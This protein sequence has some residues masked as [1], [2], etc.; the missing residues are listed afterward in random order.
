MS[1]RD[2]HSRELVCAYNRQ[3][4]EKGSKACPIMIA[5]RRS[6]D[7]LGIRILR[8]GCNSAVLRGCH[9][10]RRL[11]VGRQD[12]CGGLWAAGLGA[13]GG[14]GVGG[15]GDLSNLPETIKQCSALHDC[16]PARRVG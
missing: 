3:S 8:S 16:H 11:E 10:T 15:G 2:A 14:G 6:H 12:V 9:G 7:E 13:W 5:R 4:A 1:G